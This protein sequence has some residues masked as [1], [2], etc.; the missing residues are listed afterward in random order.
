MSKNTQAT[1]YFIVEPSRQIKR[2]FDGLHAFAVL[3]CFLNSLQ[4]VNQLIMAVMVTAFWLFGTFSRKTAS[5]YLSYT[6][7][8]GW[9]VALDGY[10]Y[11]SAMVLGTTVIASSAIF[12]HFKMDGQSSRS[13]LIARD[14]MRASD[15]RRLMVRLK[16]SGYSQGR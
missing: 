11:R 3:A 13:L 5:V 6:V 1:F 7:N 16:L 15:Y 4:F 10:N 8:K 14:S 12:L 2:V 9:E